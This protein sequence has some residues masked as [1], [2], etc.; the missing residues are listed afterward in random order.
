[1]FWANILLL[2]WSIVSTTKDPYELIVRPD[3]PEA[4]QTVTL[5]LEARGNFLAGDAIDWVFAG[6]RYASGWSLPQTFDYKLSGYVEVLDATLAKAEIVRTRDRTDTTVRLT[7]LRK[8]SSP[9]L[10]RVHRIKACQVVHQRALEG[11]VLKNDFRSKPAVSQYFS[12]SAGPPHSLHLIG[13]SLRTADSGA[14]LDFEAA[15]LD[16]FANLAALDQEAIELELIDLKNNERLQS[17]ELALEQGSGQVRISSQLPPGAYA[18]RTTADAPIRGESNPLLLTDGLQPVPEIQ[19]GDLQIHAEYSRDAITISWGEIARHSRDVAFLDFILATDHDFHY[20][21]LPQAFEQMRVDLLAEKREDFQ[22]FPGYE[23]TSEGPENQFRPVL[24]MHSWGHRQVIFKNPL[25][26]VMLSNED[27]RYRDLPQFV[28]ALR[29]AVGDDF[30]LITHHLGAGFLRQFRKGGP[31]WGEIKGLTQEDLERFNGVVEIY[32]DLGASES[33]HTEDSWRSYKAVQ[34]AKLME[35]GF[36]SRRFKDACADGRAFGVI[37]SSDG[38]SGYPGLGK[39]RIFARGLTAVYAPNN[40]AEIFDAIR[41]HQTYG[42]SSARISIYATLAGEVIGKQFSLPK[43][44]L[45]LQVEV[46]CPAPLARVV[47]VKNGIDDL[48]WS[49]QNPTSDRYLTIKESLPRETGVY[50]LRVEQQGTEQAPDGDRA[51]T[52]PWLVRE[53]E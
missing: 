14:A 45:Q 30:F 28:A 42:T 51:W 38:H 53:P 33:V 2:P 46:A 39:D 34:E 21:R 23:W 25:E 48:V 4:G 24:H 44:E 17:Y 29:K 35:M 15:S 5:E 37:A 40:R 47:L 22:V 9:V 52:S 32:S 27:K 31:W 11:Y 20:D 36:P 1:M 43:E 6:T 8:S 16:A 50:Y 41:S 26:A 10:A 49:P 3:L 7:L 12:V 18:L 13:P 19:W